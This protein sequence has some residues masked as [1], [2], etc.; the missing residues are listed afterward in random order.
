MLVHHPNNETHRAPAWPIPISQSPRSRHGDPTGFRLPDCPIRH[1]TQIAPRKTG[2]P[3]SLGDVTDTA[4]QQPSSAGQLHLLAVRAQLERARFRPHPLRGTSLRLRR[5]APSRGDHAK[6]SPV[7]TSP[8]EYDVSHGE[9]SIR[10]RAERHDPLSWG[11]PRD[12][13]LQTVGS[14]DAD[15]KIR[16]V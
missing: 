1:E 14:S 8:P 7:S 16:V 3:C 11:G 15:V 13:V 6:L 10:R 9:F 12:V 2:C 4:Y 5:V